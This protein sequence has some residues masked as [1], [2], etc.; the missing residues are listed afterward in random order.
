VVCNCEL[1]LM[2]LRS[3]Y[4]TAVRVPAVRGQAVGE[5]CTSLM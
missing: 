5:L 2:R 1:V 3:I 4:S